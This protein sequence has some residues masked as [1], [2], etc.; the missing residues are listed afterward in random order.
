MSMVPAADSAVVA[1]LLV[2]QQPSS[3]VDGK[4]MEEE[5]WRLSPKGVLKYKSEIDVVGY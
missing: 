5:Q 1:P 2:R 4:V 3:C